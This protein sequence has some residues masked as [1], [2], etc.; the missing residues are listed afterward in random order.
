VPIRLP[1]I[2]GAPYCANAIYRTIVLGLARYEH[3]IQYGM[4]V[5][6]IIARL[7]AYCANREGIWRAITLALYEQVIVGRS[8]REEPAD[9]GA[10]AKPL[11]AGLYTEPLLRA[12]DGPFG[13]SIA[14]G[15]AEHVGD[16]SRSQGEHLL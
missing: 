12:L 3:L 5:F 9:V 11:S 7:F 14:A 16:G 10:R 1:R 8:A 6:F 2:G 13:M 15:I 4:V